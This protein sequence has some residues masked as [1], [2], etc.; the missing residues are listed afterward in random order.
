MKRF[1]AGKVVGVKAGKTR[2]HLMLRGGLRCT[3]QLGAGLEGRG[4]R[5]TSKRDSTTTTTTTNSNAEKKEEGENR[6][7]T[8]KLSGGSVGAIDGLGDGEAAQDS[9][10]SNRPA[11]CIGRGGGG[12]G[13]L[14]CLIEPRCR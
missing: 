8:D 13:A 4:A 11:I 7:L 10:E 9:E 6:H 3:R 1:V 14:Q 2:I 12:G 5:N